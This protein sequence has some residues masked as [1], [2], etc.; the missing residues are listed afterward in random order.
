MI[1]ELE[2]GKDTVLNLFGAFMQANMDILVQIRL[3]GKMVE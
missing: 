3:V 2:G 1:D